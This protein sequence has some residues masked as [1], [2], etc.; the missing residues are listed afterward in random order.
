M[1]ALALLIALLALPAAAQDG[2][3]SEVG[4]KFDQSDVNRDGVVDESEMRAQERRRFVAVDRNGDGVLSGA[5]FEGGEQPAGLTEAGAAQWRASRRYQFGRLD[6]D[7]DGRLTAGEFEGQGRGAFAAADADRDGRLTRI[8]L[9][10]YM[11]RAQAAMREQALARRLV[12][13]DDDG[14]GLVDAREFDLVRGEAFARV[15]L[16]AD[17]LLTFEEFL[18]PGEAS[19]ARRARAQTEFDADDRDSDGRLNALEFRASGRRLFETLDANGDERLDMSEF[20]A[21]AGL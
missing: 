20:R 18:G 10:A 11:A 12:A 9:T 21:A 19:A 5:E 3:L 6:R 16:D 4:R 8:E 2:A 14:D 7:D 13:M 15:D 1:R 17:G